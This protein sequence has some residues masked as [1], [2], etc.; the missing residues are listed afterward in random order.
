MHRCKDITV[1]THTYLH[2]PN[3]T[4][5]HTHLHT[6]TVTHTH[7]HIHVHTYKHTHTEYAKKKKYQLGFS[8]VDLSNL[9]Q[10]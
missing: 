8:F 9:N 10:L 6:H 1:N 2:T 5:T 7:T 4:H 3:Y